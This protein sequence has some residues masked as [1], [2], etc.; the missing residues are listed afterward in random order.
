MSSSVVI[1]APGLISVP[2]VTLE[3]PS[4]PAKGA[5]I[6]RSPRRAWAAVSV[7]SAV[8]SAVAASSAET[9][10]AMPRSAS[11]LNRSDSRRAWATAARAWMI[12][13]SSSPA[14]SWTRGVPAATR[15][16]S[17]NRTAVISS[18]VADV[19]L[20]ER[21]PRATPRTSIWSLNGRSDTTASD[22]SWPLPPPGPP[23]G[24]PP[25]SSAKATRRTA[26]TIMRPSTT[27]AANRKK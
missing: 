4:T 6:S 7:A 16:P 20:T 9:R 14:W 8:S 10:G 15:W 13:A 18:D 2:G 12:E 19:T 27:A 23:L 11:W 26:A 22:T 17:R 24:P 21:R 3:S 1:T 25:S 5:R